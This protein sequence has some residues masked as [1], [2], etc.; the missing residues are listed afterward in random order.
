MYPTLEVRTAAIIED[1]Q[2]RAEH[3]RA[4]NAAAGERAS[5]LAAKYRRLARTDKRS[6]TGE[7][8]AQSS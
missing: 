8:A 1:H 2:Q 3:R 7:P 6:L 5:R 4:G